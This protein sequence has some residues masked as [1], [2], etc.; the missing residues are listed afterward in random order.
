MQNNKTELKTK[1]SRPKFRHEYFV[2]FIKGHYTNIKTRR[3]IQ[4]KCYE[5][6]ALGAIR[7]KEYVGD[8]SFLFDLNTNHIQSSILAELGRLNDEDA[9]RT[10]AKKLCD[11]A[12]T[13]KHT[14]REWQHI[15]RCFADSYR[16][17]LFEKLGLI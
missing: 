10:V 6:H 2:D 4:N 11:K 13:E 1:R 8:I 14:V 16:V 12:K 9:I 15:C 3:G 5:I 17:T 7:N